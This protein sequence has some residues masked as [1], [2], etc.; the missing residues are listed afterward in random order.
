MGLER[1]RLANIDRRLFS[2]LSHDAGPQM[3]KVPVSAAAWST[4]RR[5]CEVLGL[6]MG[7]AIAVL[8]NCELATVV[9]EAGDG[10]AAVLTIRAAEQLAARDAELTVRERN[11]KAVGER[12]RAWGERL[13]EWEDDL[14]T[15][16]VRVDDASKSLRRQRDTPPKVG[17]NE[18]CPCESGLKYKHC[19]GLPARPPN[20]VPR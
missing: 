14:E 18:R 7:E 15:R 13:R 20:V 12:Q 3:V 8:I 4:W 1:G 9:D 6:T 17:R 11:V 10:S 19:H 16:E 2:E 5:Y